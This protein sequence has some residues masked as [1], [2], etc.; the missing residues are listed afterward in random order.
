MQCHCI[1]AVNSSHDHNIFFNNC[2]FS[3]QGFVE[4]GEHL[5]L[6][7]DKTAQMS[8]EAQSYREMSHQL[9]NKVKDKKWYQF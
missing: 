4:R 2:V 1:I 7:E 8:S 5:E 9:L 3:F 6:L